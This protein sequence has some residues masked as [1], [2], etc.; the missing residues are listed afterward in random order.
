MKP[1]DEM[2]IIFFVTLVICSGVGLLTYA[3][4]KL[5]TINKRMEKYYG[6]NCKEETTETQ[7]DQDNP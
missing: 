1:I 7:T 5:T 3:A 2:I 6:K 4:Y